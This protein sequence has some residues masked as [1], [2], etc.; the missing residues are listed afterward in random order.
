MASHID[1]R[2]QEDIDGFFDFYNGDP[3]CQV[4]S[5]DLV[6]SSGH[7]ITRLSGSQQVDMAFLAEIPAFA[8]DAKHI[9]FHMGNT[10]DPLIGI[11]MA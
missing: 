7:V 9:P 6:H 5:Q 8:A 11:Q 2:V 3:L 10:L 4:I 1:L